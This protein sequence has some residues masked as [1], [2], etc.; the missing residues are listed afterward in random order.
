MK[1]NMRMKKEWLYLDV[2]YCIG[3]IIYIIAQLHH[4][5]RINDLLFLLL[6]TF[7][8]LFLNY[9]Q[10]KLYGILLLEEEGSAFWKELE[11][12]ETQKEKV[13]NMF[14]CRRYDIGAVVFAFLFCCIMWQFHI[15]EDA[16][17]IKAA[18]IFYLF[19]AN[20]PTGLAIARLL[21][22]F[23]QTVQ[24][25]HTIKFD[26]GINNSF[27]VKFVKKVRNSVL[28]TAVT[29]CTL[30]LSSILFTNIEINIIVILYTCFAAFLVISSLVITDL[31]LAGQ[32]KH[33]IDMSLQKIN[34]VISNNISTFI[35]SDGND[36]TAYKKIQR[37][38]E[39]KNYME[40]Q[41]NTQMDMGKILSNIGLVII[42]I[43]PVILQWLLE[44]LKF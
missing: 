13:K 24:W 37:L 8:T 38:I 39:V 28:F 5:R 33:N 11:E 3:M 35:E 41:K 19:F 9:R 30:S 26:V 44:S 15:W 18:F 12:G 22:Y 20:I 42:T 1:K 25:I 2:F 34:D 7:A 16:V 31:L 29:Y 17:D 36:E 6:L 21:L 10:K 43:I 4:Y 23:S 14:L 40:N 27:A 32:T